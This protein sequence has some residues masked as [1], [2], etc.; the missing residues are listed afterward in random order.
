MNRQQDNYTILWY[1]PPFF[2]R[3]RPKA[4][5]CGFNVCKYSNCKI[6]FELKHALQ[7]D[8]VI[9]DGRYVKQDAGFKRPNGQVW[10]FAAHEAP[11]AYDLVGGWWKT[12]YW[13]DQFNWTMTYN[14]NNADIFLPYGKI[15]KNVNMSFLR[16]TWK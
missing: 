11:T 9:F 7:S 4:L 3:S 10:I 1:N 16:I 5:H 14:E 8:A 13:I 12:R 2:L 6:E 15:K